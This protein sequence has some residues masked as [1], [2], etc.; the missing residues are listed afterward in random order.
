MLHKLSNYGIRGNSRDIIQSYL[1]DR[2]Q[3]VKIDNQSSEDLLVKF[4]VPQGSVLCPL[5]FL[6]YIN[7]LHQLCIDK[8][9][10][11]FI[12]YAD[13]T[14]IFVACNSINEAAS[15][16]QSLLERVNSYMISNLLHI[17]L[18]KCSFTYF[19]QRNRLMTKRNG[20]KKHKDINSNTLESDQ[21]V[22]DKSG[23]MLY[24]GDI[25]IKEVCEIP[26]LGVIIDNKLSWSAHIDYLLKKLRIA[27][28]TIKRIS[29]CIPALYHTNI[30][31]TLFE[32]HISYCISVWGGAKKKLIENVFTL[33]KRAVRCLFGD[34]NSF[35]NKFCTAART[36]QYGEQFLGESFFK[37]SIPSLC[38]R[39][40]NCLQLAIYTNTWQLTK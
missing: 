9:H 1:S 31:H 21:A 20:A 4:G 32:S 40:V 34:R 7:D 29:G 17:N 13:D 36:R 28:A 11:K 38:S 5:L 14:N 15:I 10:I 19:P 26:F 12:L 33:Q 8:K 2:Y 27:L 30:Y 3:R 6:L 39:T 35:M 16:T 18:D 22:P 37:K 25:Q 23:I 24:I